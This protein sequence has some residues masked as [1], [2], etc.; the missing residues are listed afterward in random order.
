VQE[1]GA[2]DTPQGPQTLDLRMLPAAPEQ[3]KEPPIAPKA[4]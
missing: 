1:H 2:L 3:T 4:T